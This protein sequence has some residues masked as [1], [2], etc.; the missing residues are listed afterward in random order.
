MYVCMYVFM[1][2]YTYI[3]MYILLYTLYIWIVS[4]DLWQR[5]AVF[6]L[7]SDQNENP[8]TQN[9]FYIWIYVHTSMYI[10]VCTYIYMYSFR[11]TLCYHL[12]QRFAV[13]GLHSDQNETPAAQ[14]NMH[15][16]IRVHIYIYI[17]IYA[18]VHR[19]IDV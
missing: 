13:F 4:A 5:F 17:Y 3:H 8:A 10:C 11:Y 2:G 6:G 12:R 15:T 9:N 19:D 18:F 14:Y 7:H 1:Y 16:C